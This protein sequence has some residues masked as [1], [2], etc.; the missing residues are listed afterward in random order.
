M[1]PRDFTEL[2]NTVGM[3]GAVLFIVCS[4]LVAVLYYAKT[5]I[6]SWGEPWIKS[7]IEL[8][9]SLI[10]STK[11]HAAS[12]ESQARSIEALARSVNA[13][14][15]STKM[16]ARGVSQMLD[17]GDGSS[18]IKLE[19]LEFKFRKLSEEKADVEA[20]LDVMREEL[21]EPDDES[22]P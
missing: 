14:E 8:T 2:V 13:I 5:K 19:G 10:D 1:S 12:S 9:Q 17:A 6:D 7:Q 18:K 21:K 15:D 3:F 11:T 16:L 22:K 20:E 4:I